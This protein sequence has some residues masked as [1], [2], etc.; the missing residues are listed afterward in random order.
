MSAADSMGAATAVVTTTTATTTTVVAVNAAA[1]VAAAVAIGI[2]GSPTPMD[3]MTSGGG[4]ETTAAIESNVVGG[5]VSIS[6]DVIAAISQAHLTN[7][8]YTDE[9]TRTLLRK[10]VAS[11]VIMIFYF[12]NIVTT[13]SITSRAYNMYGR[14]LNFY[15]YS[16]LPPCIS[17]VDLYYISSPSN[18]SEPSQSSSSKSSY[19][20][21]LYACYIGI[22]FLQSSLISTHI[23]HFLP[24][25][26]LI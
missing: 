4:A 21:L 12:D 5:G 8:D 14:V 19:S 26:Y 11:P 1:A 6:Y 15:I 25:P 20:H 3:T 13:M 18:I 17:R 10:P 22:Y 7:C 2:G 24:G 9:L 23:F 16:H